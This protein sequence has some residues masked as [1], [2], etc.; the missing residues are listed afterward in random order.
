MVCRVPKLKE[1]EAEVKR[2]REEYEAGVKK[3]KANLDDV[4]TSAR[5]VINKYKLKDPENA[6]VLDQALKRQAK[7]D[8]VKS[9]VKI[10][11]AIDDFNRSG[12]M[13]L[14]QEASKPS[15]TADWLVGNLLR[16]NKSVGGKL[17]SSK[18]QTAQWM[19]ANIFG[20]P[21][22]EGGRM[23]RL[24]RAGE[25]QMHSLQMLQ[26][27]GE[28]RLKVA[29]KEI[30]KRNGIW[31]ETKLVERNGSTHPFI[32]K[33]NEDV[34][35][36][37]N[38]LRFGRKG[39]EDLDV[40][41]VSKVLDNF[42]KSSFAE[43]SRNGFVV[44][45][46]EDNYQNLRLHKK[47]LEILREERGDKFVFDL[48][49]G[50]YKETGM[51]NILAKKLIKGMEEVDEYF[52]STFKSSLPK[53]REMDTAFELDGVSLRSIL[54]LDIKSQMDTSARNTAGWV[55]LSKATKGVIKT[56][57]D[58]ETLVD[59]LKRE[60]VKK[61][62]DT[63]DIETYIQDDMNRMFGQPVR[64]GLAHEVV[65]LKNLATGVMMGKS[66]I[67]QSMD[68]GS[69]AI[70]GIFNLHDDK[71]LS[72]LLEMTGDRWEKIP[73]MRELQSMIHMLDGLSEIK[74]YARFI[75]RGEL[76]DISKV[77]QMS[78]STLDLLTGGNKAPEL[79]ST[80][81]KVN[82]NNVVSNKQS[83]VIMASYMLSVAKHF[84]D[85]SSSLSIARLMDAGLTDRFGKSDIMTAAFKN[86]EFDEH[87][88]LKSLNL[89]KWSEEAKEKFTIAILRTES[90]EVQ[91]TL[92]GD[93]PTW[94]NPL[95]FQV[96]NQFKEFSIV[97]TS[98]QMHRQVKF[99]DKEAVLSVAMNVALVG[100]VRTGQFKAAA[101][102]KALITGDDFSSAIEEE[103]TYEQAKYQN[104]ITHLGAASLAY[105][106]IAAGEKAL[107]QKTVPEI[108]EEGG[109]SLLTG[110]PVGGV[111]KSYYD[112]VESVILDEP[113]IKTL[114]DARKLLW[115]QNSVYADMILSS[116]EE[117]YKK[118]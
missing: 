86:S 91:R 37:L 68:S 10:T 13:A 80:L 33:L 61:G 65:A 79:L 64:G 42:N 9:V 67:A 82:F 90:T 57:S 97:G 107:E 96:I 101:G 35:I 60:G 111:L 109:L 54:D 43:S 92:V 20:V 93:L 23:T 28:G 12:L 15:S 47:E 25:W 53:L 98:K 44:G 66:G 51:Q 78:M 62:I 85:G 27:A 108:L 30:A 58:L 29:M 3:H 14:V 40:L 17:R 106:F 63:S 36:H 72:R 83:E 56:P 94:V 110:V 45:T 117:F 75:E 114:E 59:M 21:E 31:Q 77:R 102:A 6:L 41:A 5:S 49:A 74:N 105:E 81:N 88:L 26:T 2:A 70:K 95:A 118:F 34:H 46:L 39:S 55:G 4:D 113:A 112:T 104:Y 89:D 100:L 116:M 115:Y 103:V 84:N 38:D 19:S 24:A 48:I 69:A 8:K 71:Y 32:K 87:G 50:G 52:S 76:N 1:A 7:E 11:N 99:A 18:L 16:W 22:G 73:I